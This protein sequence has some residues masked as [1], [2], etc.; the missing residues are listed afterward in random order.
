MR[1]KTSLALSLLLATAMT[2]AAAVPDMALD[3]AGTL[4]QL[5]NN[6]TQLIL[7]VR[8]P[9]GD[10]PRLIA[11]P[12]TAGYQTS[13]LSVS[14]DRPNKTAVLAWQ[15]NLGPGLSRVMV[16]TYHEGTWFGPLSVSETGAGGVSA[17]NPVLLVH[18][19]TL[20]DADGNPYQQAF[21][22]LAWWADPDAPDGGYAMYAY[23]RLNADGTPILSD[24]HPEELHSSMPYGLSCSLL[25]HAAT[26]AHPKLIIDP[27]TGDPQLLFAD[28]DQCLLTVIDLHP[29]TG[30][31]D[32]E[33]SA[34]AQ[35]KRN[36]IVFGVRKQIFVTPTLPFDHAEIAIGHNLSVVMYWD[37]DGAIDYVTMDDQKTSDI[38]SIPLGEGLNHEKAVQL[39][40]RLV[41][42][43]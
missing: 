32:G 29:D 10:P 13:A 34:T 21:I 19:S 8:S 35:R 37:T 20:A 33:P 17:I 43:Q 27:Q 6:G 38:S 41:E 26:F 11:V 36:V 9:G 5:T 31:H 40:D 28:L 24:L 3:H 12:Q 16:A 1:T 42:A 23:M 18:R 4:Y 30:D 7:S 39:I 2:A 25:D 14:L 22:H 15:E